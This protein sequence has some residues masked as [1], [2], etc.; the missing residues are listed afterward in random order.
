MPAAETRIT[1]CNV[2]GVRS[3]C[4]YVGGVLVMF[5]RPEGGSY[6]AYDVDA[7]SASA[8]YVTSLPDYYEAFEALRLAAEA[9]RR[10]N[11]N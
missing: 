9:V 2:N 3:L 11:T 8:T 5:A 1:N 6:R 7:T 4:L 10:S